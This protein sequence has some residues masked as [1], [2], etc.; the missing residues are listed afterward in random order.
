M[1]MSL[2]SRNSIPKPKTCR[3]TLKVALAV[4]IVNS[5]DY[6]KIY[7]FWKTSWI[8]FKYKNSIVFAVLYVT[9]Q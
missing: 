7:R 1:P 4:L 8:T 2:F 5:G 9:R 6:D 3:I